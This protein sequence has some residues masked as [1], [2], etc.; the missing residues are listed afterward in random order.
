MPSP[1]LCAAGKRLRAQIDAR[2]PDRDKASDGWI[3]DESHPSTSDHSP[4]LST[5]V[6][7]AIDVDEDLLGPLYRDNEIA[8]RLVSELVASRDERLRYLIFESQIWSASSGWSARRYSGSNAH[9]HHIHISF[10]RIGDRDGRLFAIPLLTGSL[11]K[12]ELARGSV[13]DAVL[14]VQGAIRSLHD[15]LLLDGRSFPGLRLKLDGQF[16][17]A[18][19]RAVR[20]LE[21]L[22]ALPVTGVVTPE[23]ERLLGV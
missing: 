5:G 4:D 8:D 9:A 13:G 18:T 14:L 20:A 2:F 23:L 19:E 6:V 16:G 12:R 17:P 7:R 3:A 22:Y 15:Q 10:T 21:G 1:F 11:P